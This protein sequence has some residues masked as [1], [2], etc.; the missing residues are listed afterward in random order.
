VATP[1]KRYFRVGDSILREPWPREVKLACVLLQAHLNTR[2]RR[3][4]IPHD[5]AGICLLSKGAWTDITGKSHAKSAQKLLET[6]A[7]FVNLS[8]KIKTENDLTYIRVDWPKF[9][10]YQEFGSRSPG[11]DEPLFQPPP[12]PSPTPT[13]IH[14]PSEGGAKAPNQGDGGGEKPKPKRSK[15][16]PL[17][18][19]IPPDMRA[20]IDLLCLDNDVPADAFIQGLRDYATRS[21]KRYA[22]ERGWLAACRSAIREK[23]SFVPGPPDQPKLNYAERSVQETKEAA[24]R[25]LAE[26]MGR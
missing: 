19:P 10:E 20:K 6:L 2:W 14:P 17:P 12:S 5:E 4:A 25:V 8:A 18:D 16:C 11:S 7:T 9:A 21:G 22:G 1:R 24:R 15:L 13:P 3:D 26:A 23:W